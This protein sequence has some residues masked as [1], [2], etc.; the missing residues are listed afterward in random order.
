MTNKQ[1]LKSNYIFDMS[2]FQPEHTI[3]ILETFENEL[4]NTIKGLSDAQLNWKINTNSWSCYEVI[5]HLNQ[6]IVGYISSIDAT[7]NEKQNNWLKKIPFYNKPFEASL[8]WVVK[9]SQG[10]KVKSPQVFQ[11]S[12]STYTHQEQLVF[13]R[14]LKKLRD[15]IDWLDIEGLGKIKIQSPLSKAIILSLPA[16]LEI[17]CNHNQRHLQQI[18]RVIAHA[19]FP[20]E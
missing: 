6:A 7:V 14:S 9:P 17:I 12:A 10:I 18:Q 16:T 2:T 8:N 3:S 1:N 11:P 19:Q 20:K 15:L 4:K 5:D 13:F